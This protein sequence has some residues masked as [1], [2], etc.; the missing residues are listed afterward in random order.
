MPSQTKGFLFLFLV[1]REWEICTSIGNQGY[2]ESSEIIEGM[3]RYKCREIE[4][5]KSKMIKQS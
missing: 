5:A 3:Q 1:K 2:V 4:H